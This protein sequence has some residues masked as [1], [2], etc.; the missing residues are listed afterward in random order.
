MANLSNMAASIPLKDHL[1][2]VPNDILLGIWKLIPPRHQKLRHNNQQSQQPERRRP[3]L[4][5]L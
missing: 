4:Q 2:S 3:L 1:S 5:P